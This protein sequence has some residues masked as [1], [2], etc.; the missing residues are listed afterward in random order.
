MKVGPGRKLSKGAAQ[1]LDWP[2]VLLSTYPGLFSVTESKGSTPSQLPPLEKD[3]SRGKREPCA[4][5]LQEGLREGTL[6]ASV[7]AE[8]SPCTTRNKRYH[9][10]F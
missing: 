3:K 8:R 4:G 1:A 6:V 9:C 5:S 7:A 10:G 2:A